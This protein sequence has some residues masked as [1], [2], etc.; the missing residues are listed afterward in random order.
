M[1]LF[2]PEFGLAF[3][4]LVVFLV[5]L[6]LLGKFAWP[7]I[8]RS[9]DERAAFIDKGVEYTRAAQADREEARADAERM[10]AEAHRQQLEVLQQTEQLK[11]DMLAKAQA[12]AEAEAARVKEAARLA[13]EQAK[14]DA[15][16]ELRAQVATLSLQIAGRLVREDLSTDA[17]QAAMVGKML[18]ELER[19]E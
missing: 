1:S 17:A 9:M 3:W 16:A 14:R 12:A 18:D 8:I 2:T 11:R 13:V 19:K 4:M 7:V 15:E 6:G 10:V 5:L